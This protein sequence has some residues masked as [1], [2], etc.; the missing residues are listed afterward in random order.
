MKRGAE[1]RPN[2]K[3][4]LAILLILAL[5]LSLLGAY[6]SVYNANT[7]RTLSTS[8]IQLPNKATANVGISI[9]ETPEP[10][11]PPSGENTP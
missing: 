7:L 4:F 8:A 9:R 1:K 10:V 2:S 11:N 6:M 3:N 5:I